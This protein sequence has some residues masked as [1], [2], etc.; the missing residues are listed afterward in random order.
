MH[1]YEVSYIFKGDPGMGSLLIV[2][3]KLSRI[4]YGDVEN[5]QKFE[6]VYDYFRH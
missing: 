2:V 3:I 4:K 6:Y 5:L 1:Y